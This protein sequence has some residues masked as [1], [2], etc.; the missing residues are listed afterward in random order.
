MI[1]KT[2]A[3]LALVSALAVGLAVGQLTTHISDRNIFVPG[4]V[5]AGTIKADSII[6]KGEDIDSYTW[7]LIAEKLVIINKGD[8]QYTVTE[9]SPTLKGEV[10]AD[11]KYIVF[12]DAVHVI[13]DNPSGSGVNLTFE[14]SAVLD[15]GSET[16]IA[17]QTI[18][19]G[20]VW[21]DWLIH[22]LDK[23]P[24]GRKIKCI[25]LYA[26]VSGTPASGS[27]PTVQLER[28]IGVQI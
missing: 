22:F 7:N 12:P 25:R 23:I 27:E 11:N 4:T 16:V 8:S 9:T 20:T 19:D 1:N 14:V 2:Y 15:D 24:N 18:T 21:D 5:E 28:V 26:N 10:C 6:Y 17:T 13:A 3:L